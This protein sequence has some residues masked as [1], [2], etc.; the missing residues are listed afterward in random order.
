M[1][2][3][4]I[5]IANEQEVLQS[6]AKLSKCSWAPGVTKAQF[7]NFSISKIFDPTL[8]AVKFSPQLSCGDTCQI[9]MWYSIANM[10]S[11]D[12]EKNKE[13][14]RMEEIGLVTPTPA[15]LSGVIEQ[16]T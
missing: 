13:N 1:Q 15:C 11:G 8:V 10:Y 14:N 2:D 4:S 9:W 7:V 12:A 6:C 5:S 3:C 16:V